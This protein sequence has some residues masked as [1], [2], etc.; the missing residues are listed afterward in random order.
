VEHAVIKSSRKSDTEW[1]GMAADGELLYLFNGFDQRSE[2][3]VVND[4]QQLV[5][6]KAAAHDPDLETHPVRCVASTPGAQLGFTFRDSGA[7]VRVLSAG[8]FPS[9]YSFDD[10]GD[11]WHWIVRC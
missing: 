10:L 2:I 7:S 4:F 8:G 3:C 6:V 1:Q 5:P 9:T 11:Y